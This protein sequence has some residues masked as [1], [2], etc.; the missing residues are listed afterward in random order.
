MAPGGALLLDMR[1]GRTGGGNAR[2]GELVERRGG[3]A[4]VPTGEAGMT[5]IEGVRAMMGGAA[6]GDEEEEE[7]EE[8]ATGVGEEGEEDGDS[9]EKISA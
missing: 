3:G 6:V 8:E 9:L 2:R 4:R 5:P 7:E 1:T